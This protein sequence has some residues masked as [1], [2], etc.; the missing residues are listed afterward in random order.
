MT[1]RSIGKLACH[2]NTHR[3]MRRC[4]AEAYLR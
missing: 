2:V 4:A 1:R 3:K